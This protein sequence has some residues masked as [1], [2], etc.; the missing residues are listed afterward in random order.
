VS[1]ATAII[2]VLGAVLNSLMGGGVG[3]IMPMVRYCVCVCV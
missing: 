2:E 1:I 3:P